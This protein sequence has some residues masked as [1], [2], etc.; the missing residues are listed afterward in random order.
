MG[1]N[2]EEGKAQVQAACTMASSDVMISDEEMERCL[3]NLI[4]QLRGSRQYCRFKN[5]ADIVEAD[6]QKKERIDQFRR[7]VYLT[8]N[9][10]EPMERIE[11]MNA[12]SRSRHEIY[13]DPVSA[14]F[15][16]AELEICR[17]LQ[18]ICFSVLEVVNVGID[19]FE[20]EVD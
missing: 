19:S 15:L 8:Q 2:T 9:T 12:L 18:H 17:L 16:E 7:Q 3:H 14:E 6:P 10:G 4:A 20:H 5:I 13:Q 1:K 11:E